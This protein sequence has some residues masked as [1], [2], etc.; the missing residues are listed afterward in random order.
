MIIDNI[1]H[2]DCAEHPFTPENAE[3]DCRSTGAYRSSFLLTT[4]SAR[5]AA[6]A[7]ATGDTF[8]GYGFANAD[9]FGAGQGQFTNT[10]I[11]TNARTTVGYGHAFS[12]GF[13]RIDTVAVNPNSYAQA[14]FNGLSTYTASK[15][16]AGSRKLTLSTHYS[17]GR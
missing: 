1:E 12:Q 10:R 8:A 16:S 7:F 4:T 14:N 13:A 3:T 15:G 17:T 11:D 6:A 5:G 2:I 9:G